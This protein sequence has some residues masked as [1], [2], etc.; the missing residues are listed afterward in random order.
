MESQTDIIFIEPFD[1][2]QTWSADRFHQANWNSVDWFRTFKTFLSLWCVRNFIYLLFF[3]HTHKIIWNGCD[4]HATALR[5]N[6]CSSCSRWFAQ[7]RIF[8]FN[9]FFCFICSHLCV[10]ALFCPV[11]NSIRSKRVTTLWRKF[12]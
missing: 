5:S 4:A 12:V 1:W 3:S 7:Q 2:M 11:A 10:Y 8:D 6:S 9:F